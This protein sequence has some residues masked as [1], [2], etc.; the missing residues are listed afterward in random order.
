MEAQGNILKMRTKLSEPVE[1]SLPI[2]DETFPMNEKLGKTLKLEFTGKINCIA[3][4]EEIKK[5]Y[6]QGYSYKA[7][8]T[9]AQCDMCIVKPELC[10]YDKGTCREPKWGEEHCMQPH[11]VYLANTSNV[12]IGITRRKN[13][14]FRWIDQGAHEALPILEVPTRKLSGLIEVEIKRD[15]SDVT[16]WRKMLTNDYEEVDLYAVRDEI[17]ENLGPVLDDLEAEDIEEDIVQIQ[18]PVLEYPKKVSSLSFDKNPVIEG[19]LQGIKGQ[20]LIFDKGVIN[21]RKFQGYEIK[22]T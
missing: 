16:N 9:L 19:T 6:G 1:Y 13:V 18:Y 11:V 7:F 2:G 14:P 12:K 21:L 8:S 3:T 10:H 20:Y 5:S 17:Y 4:G 22:L 15:M